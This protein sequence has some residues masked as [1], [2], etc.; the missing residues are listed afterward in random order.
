MLERAKSLIHS[1]SGQ[2]YPVSCIAASL[3]E[4]DLVLFQ[5]SLEGGTGEAFTPMPVSPYTPEAPARVTAYTYPER[6][7]SSRH[8]L[9]YR[10][11]M[12]KEAKVGTYDDLQ[13]FLIEPS[14]QVGTSGSPVL[15][16]AGAVIGIIRGNT[17]PSPLALKGCAFGTPASKL[18]DMFRVPGMP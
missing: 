3:C 4:S 13:S 15:D 16:E 9:G 18:W 8:L 7:W 5:F 6:D 1:R 14:V 17:G 12:G 10:D 2:V 11:S